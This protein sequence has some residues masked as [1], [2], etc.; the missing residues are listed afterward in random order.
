MLKWS[1]WPSVNAQL[2][3]NSPEPFSG[4]RTLNNVILVPSVAAG[5]AV[6]ILVGV[7]VCVWGVWVKSCEWGCV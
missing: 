4:F 6:Y 7:G 3:H 1:N 2:E 5:A